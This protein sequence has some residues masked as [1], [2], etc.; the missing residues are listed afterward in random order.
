MN[1]ARAVP[2]CKPSRRKAC[3]AIL[4]RRGILFALDRQPRLD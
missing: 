2:K 1:V 4:D 3:D